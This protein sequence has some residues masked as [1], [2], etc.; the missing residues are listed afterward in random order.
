MPYYAGAGINGGTY[1]AP[2][3]NGNANPN[4]FNPAGGGATQ[5]ELGNDYARPLPELTDLFMRHMSYLGF[6]MYLKTLGFTKGV[7]TQTVGHYEQPW[8]DQTFTVGSIITPSAGVG[9]G[10]VIALDTT[11][12]YAAGATVSS[13]ARKTSRPRV[14][15]VVV[16]ADGTNAQITAKT[17]STD[18]HRITITPLSPSVDLVDKIVAGESYF[19]SHNL[20]PEGSGLPETVATRTFRYTNTFATIKEAVKIT[21]TELTNSIYHEQ[22]GG[23]AP[24]KSIVHSLDFS[25]VERFENAIGN[26]YLHGQQATNLSAVMTQFNNIDTTISGTEGFVE[27]AQTAGNDVDYTTGAFETADLQALADVYYNNRAS[28]SGNILG[29]VGKELG[30]DIENAYTTIIDA[31]G[32][33]QNMDRIVVDEMKPMLSAAMSNNMD[34]K[35]GDLTIAFGYRAI[36]TS[37]MTFHL[38]NLGEFADAQNAGGS[39]YQHRKWG[40]WAP[41]SFYT[42]KNG[43]GQMGSI[44]Y[45][46]KS[47]DGYSRDVRMGKFGGAGT[48]GEGSQYGAPVHEYDYGQSFMIHEGA[49]HIA[50]GNAV[51]MM[52]PTA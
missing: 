2:G 26:L 20:F 31:G 22:P 6:R 15:D 38:K 43:G 48:A 18:P 35:S 3:T 49:F 36:R 1:T 28:L 16:L 27:F 13:S 51:T 33:T 52:K 14:Y 46:Y 25:A 8:N 23:V 50:C 17:V 42:D 9:T 40:I 41:Y 19:I 5:T 39:I 30:D 21:G 47:L 12:M 44:G 7:S 45:H 37:N 32:Y 24:G 29:F 10:V 11:D 4:L 34:Y